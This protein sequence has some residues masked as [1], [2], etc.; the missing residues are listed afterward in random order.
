MFWIKSELDRF[1]HFMI[2]ELKFNAYSY[3]IK[4]P[5]KINLLEPVN[6]E[7]AIDI[8]GKF[9]RIYFSRE[10]LEI[11]DAVG[12]ADEKGTFIKRDLWRRG[13]VI[14]FSG[15]SICEL[16]PL[17]SMTFGTQYI[18]DLGEVENK[19]KTFEKDTVQV[20]NWLRGNYKHK[21]NSHCFYGEQAYQKYLEK[22]Q[23]K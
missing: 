7:R 14:E 11:E 10:K 19:S 3:F 17:Y 8:A 18:N 6:L 16:G 13:E 15:V 12:Y 4:E 9:C 5:E 23:N 22:Q 20:M 1:L 21:L 2:E